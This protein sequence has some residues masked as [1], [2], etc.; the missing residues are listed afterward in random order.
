MHVG[1]MEIMTDAVE[2][3]VDALMAIVVDHDQDLL[4]EG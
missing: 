4:Q 3:A 2:C 1:K